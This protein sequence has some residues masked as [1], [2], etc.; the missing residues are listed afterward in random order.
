VRIGEH[1]LNQIAFDVGGTG[2]AKVASGAVLPV[3]IFSWG[4]ID[5]AIGFVLPEFEVIADVAVETKKLSRYTGL[6]EDYLVRA[7][8]RM[9]L[10]QFIEELQ[11]SRGLTTGRLDAR[12][13]GWTYDLLAEFA[14]YDPQSTAITGAFTAALWWC[15][16]SV[17]ILLWGPRGPARR[18]CPFPPPW[19]L[20]LGHVPERPGWAT[21]RKKE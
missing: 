7:N 9:T 18:T 21:P 8:L 20:C 14:D 15:D 19:S 13:S 6:Q 2:E 1:G 16:R 11:R 5:G 3:P 10:P 12:Y 4:T 17:R